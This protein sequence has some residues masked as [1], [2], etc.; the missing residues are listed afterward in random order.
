MRY[1]LLLAV[2]GCDDPVTVMPDAAV[3]ATVDAP[4]GGYDYFGETCSPPSSLGLVNTCR[5]ELP[6]PKAYCTPEGVCRPFCGTTCP[7]RQT[8]AFPTSAA[9]VCYCEPAQ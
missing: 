3:D 7:G 2:L 6:Y 1:L 9:R 8:Y 5:D 4:D